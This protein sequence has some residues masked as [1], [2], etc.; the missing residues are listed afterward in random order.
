MKHL[1]TKT[2]LLVTLL[3]NKVKTVFAGKTRNSLIINIL[4]NSLIIRYLPPPQT[5]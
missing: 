2:S 1:L 4:H 5:Y 3:L